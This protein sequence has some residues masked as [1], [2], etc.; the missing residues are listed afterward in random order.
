MLAVAQQRQLHQ[1]QQLQ[2]QHGSAA[3]L[4]P[5]AEMSV[6]AASAAAV[7]RQLGAFSEQHRQTGSPSYAAMEA[8]TFG[9]MY[10]AAPPTVLPVSAF[11][12]FGQQI[13][14]PRALH[15]PTLMAAMPPVQA[16]A[17]KIDHDAGMAL[18]ALAAAA[19]N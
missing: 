15:K 6:Q 4:Q 3:T 13:S 10:T 11:M 14:T 9:G 7:A 8:R 12:T 18:L 5:N 19:C 2:Q 16:P 1:Q 17:P